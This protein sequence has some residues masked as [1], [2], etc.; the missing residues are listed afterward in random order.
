MSVSAKDN[1][2]K[3]DV[4]LQPETDSKSR[5]IQSLQKKNSALADKVNSLRA[6]VPARGSITLS[7]EGEFKVTR[8]LR[9]NGK[10]FV[11]LERAQLGEAAK[12]LAPILSPVVTL[13]RAAAL[14]YDYNRRT[15]AHEVDGQGRPTKELQRDENGNQVWLPN[16]VDRLVAIG[17]LIAKD[18]K[19]RS[20]LAE[21]SKFLDKQSQEIAKLANKRANSKS[22]GR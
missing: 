2:L 15:K 3:P 11:N 22:Q 10:D 16:S 5:L 14:G 18:D 8:N 21:L 19:A 7:S 12:A 6:K 1:K 4:A 20:A 9:L 13:T 17:E